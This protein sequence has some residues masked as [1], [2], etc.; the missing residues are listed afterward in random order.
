MAYLLDADIIIEGL[1]GNGATLTLLSRIAPEELAI[2]WPTLGE[3]YAG[4]YY[5]SN[6]DARLEQARGFLRSY[7]RVGFDEA[8]MQRFGELRSFLRRRG[9][10]ITDIDLLI[11]AT[12][13]EYD[14]TLLTYNRRHFGRIPGLRVFASS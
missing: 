1:K 9:Q 7:A 6:P 11:A 5:S 13:V 12:A 14:F 4:A 8:I 10:P 3:V 2:S